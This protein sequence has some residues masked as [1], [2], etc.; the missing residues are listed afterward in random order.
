MAVPMAP[1]HKTG[2]R[3]PLLVLYNSIDSIFGLMPQ[4]IYMPLSLSVERRPEQADMLGLMPS[5]GAYSYGM[6]C[7]KCDSPTP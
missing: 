2:I 1:T 3:L 6:D 4:G 7:I 5:R